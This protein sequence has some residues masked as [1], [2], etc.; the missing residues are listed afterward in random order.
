MSC[1]PVALL[2]LD[3]TKPVPIPKNAITINKIIIFIG[4]A[5][6]VDCSLNVCMMGT[7]FS[8]GFFTPS[9]S[10]TMGVLGFF[11]SIIPSADVLNK[12]RQVY[13]VKHIY[14]PLATMA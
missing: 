1:L 14:S 5:D 3:M 4:D 2:T 13:L 9:F 6:E 8:S 7:S 10:E 11:L 12:L